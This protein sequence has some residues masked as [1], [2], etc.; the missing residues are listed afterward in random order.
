[1]DDIIFS[2]EI[3]FDHSEGV[4]KFNFVKNILSQNHMPA[5]GDGQLSQ[6]AYTHPQI[7][8][9]T[10][11]GMSVQPKNLVLHDGGSVFARWY[12]SV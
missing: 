5:G 6:T 7:S 12:V 11:A 2:L 10:S 1:M 4:A 9:V 8:L 3:C